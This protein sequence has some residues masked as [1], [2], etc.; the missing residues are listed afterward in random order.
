MI[1][2]IWFAISLHLWLSLN[3]LVVMCMSVSHY[4]C[5]VAKQFHPGILNWF[6]PHVFFFLQWMKTKYIKW[7]VVSLDKIRL[8]KDLLILSLQPRLLWRWNLINFGNIGSINRYN[9]CVVLYDCINKIETFSNKVT[10]SLNRFIV[11]I[12]VH[13]CV[14]QKYKHMMKIKKHI[15]L[16]VKIWR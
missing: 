8:E 10:L 11:F 14:L 5:N 6:I 3:G 4:S 12:R 7:F 15:P 13:F 1:N 9:K 2:F 16:W